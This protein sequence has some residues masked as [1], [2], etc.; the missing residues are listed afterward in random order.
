MDRG[1]AVILTAFVGGAI[2]YTNAELTKADLQ[3]ALDAAAVSVLSEIDL[4]SDDEVRQSL[5]QMIEKH[6]YTEEDVKSLTVSIDRKRR[7]VMCRATVRVEATLASLISP[8]YVDVSAMTEK[9]AD[10]H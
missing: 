3:E 4:K 7:R 8:D 6:L 5:V 9:S 10:G 2:D 1:A